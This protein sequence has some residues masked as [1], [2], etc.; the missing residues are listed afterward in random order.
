MASRSSGFTLV[1]AHEKALDCLAVAVAEA[2]GSDPFARVVVVAD[3]ADVAKT[4]RHHLGL[5]G[6]INVTVQ[7]GRR[8]ASELAAHALA[9]AGP[10]PLRPLPRVLE[11]QAV[12]QVMAD[13]L[14]A[15][16]LALSSGGRRRLAYSLRAEFH[17]MA[18]RVSEETDEGDIEALYR[19]YRGLL[20]ARGYFVPSDL[21]AMAA[22]EVA[23]GRLMDSELPFVIYYLPRRLSEGAVDLVQALQQRGR[24]HILGLV[25]GDEEADEP[26]L[27]L[28]QRLHGDSLPVPDGGPS[29]LEQVSQDRTS[30]LA[31][32][33]PGE[34]IRTVIRHMV[35]ADG[36]PDRAPPFHRIAIV[37]P[38]HDSLYDSLLRQALADAG[39]PV[40]G[41]MP[42]SPLGHTPPGRLLAGIM[43]L[44]LEVENGLDQEQLIDWLTTAP[45]KYRSRTGGSAEGI[46]QPGP[47]AR[48]GELARR[49][50]ARGTPEQWEDCL[51]T[52]IETREHWAQEHRDGQIPAYMKADRQM[53]EDLI[54]FLRGDGEQP[55]LAVRLR[56]L[57]RT[58]NWTAAIQCL[59]A[60]CRDYRWTVLPAYRQ[61]TGARPA[62]DVLR[63]EAEEAAWMRLDEMLDNLATLET[64]SADFSL[65][66]L[67]QA[68]QDVLGSAAP[69]LGT[70]PVGTGVYVGPPGGIVGTAYDTVYIVGMVE[71]QFP[72]PPRLSAWRF[73][74]PDTLQRGVALA[75]YDFL[76]ALAAA[77]Q[78]VLCWPATVPERGSAYPSRWLIEVAN[79][80]QAR[81]WQ[82]GMLGRLTY[83]NLTRDAG[84]KPW[85]TVIPSREAS[86][87]QLA[88]AA[89]LQPLHAT[90]YTMM[91]VLA[92]RQQ[93]MVQGPGL[94]RSRLRQQVA[95]HAA[96]AGVRRLAQ[97]LQAENARWSRT[98]T[99]WDGRV[100]G[101]SAWLAGIGMQTQPLAASG[102]ETWATCPYQFFLSRGL[103]LSERETEASTEISALDRGLLVHRILERFARVP[104]PTGDRLD[105]L[106]EEEFAAAERHGITGHYLL[107]EIEKESIRQRLR[108]FQ[109]RE[110]KWLAREFAGTDPAQVRAE[111]VFG[112]PTRHGR[113]AEIEEV[114]IEVPGLGAVWFQG[115][116]DRIDASGSRVRVRDFK[117]GNKKSADRYRN[118]EYTIDNGR[119]LQLPI[120]LEAMRILYP[121]VRELVGS[122]CFPL[123]DGRGHDV[124][125]YWGTDR[126][127]ERFHAVLCHIVG[128][129]RR[130]LFPAT[131]E[132]NDWGGNCHFCD[133][134]R[135]CPE[136]RH[137]MWDRKRDH[138][139]VLQ[140]VNA[141]RAPAAEGEGAA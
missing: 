131:P 44:A 2:Q 56:S 138:D 49:A 100:E 97:A 28:W 96:I 73:E 117:T 23:A 29:V 34:E 74:D 109:T 59:R 27:A 3:H 76:G 32:P 6:R 137:N 139:P 82:S 115:R 72:A 99:V 12:Q 111:L 54:H 64:W 38:P 62:A 60:L 102:L 70:T 127:R 7:T 88:A 43:A 122:Y 61:E 24:C 126:D 106:A 22:A 85:L 57:A 47:G 13:W 113:K 121:E 110:Q 36:H 78:A 98:L 86:L 104:D 45:V 84:A 140:P 107:W 25:M 124:G 11:I 116:V 79:R 14:A 134:R 128:A 41:R 69:A 136:Q 8:L 39:I 123:V 20:R 120:Y 26:V 51:R 16:E 93:V 87:Q 103:G 71:R 77:R 75:R 108:H 33:D 19:R 9:T 101:D 130:G 132:R 5:Q 66:A 83:E 94:T 48:W 68:V 91:H 67:Q 4:A 1:S 17:R 42:G 15:Q 65:P 95:T 52:Y 40:A 21:P 18:E 112:V 129:A 63:H 141:L 46:W 80:L 133:F 89:T 35:A 90:D 105:A 30:I 58:A 135:L 10:E 125:A 92:H 37:H 55:G 31:V 81:H 119:A 53:V 114:G 50:Q 118:G